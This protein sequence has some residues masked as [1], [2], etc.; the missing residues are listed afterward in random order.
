M[1]CCLMVREKYNTQLVN[2][3][4]DLGPIAHAEVHAA[5]HLGKATGV[6]HLGKAVGGRGASFDERR[7][8]AQFFSYHFLWMFLVLFSSFLVRH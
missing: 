6:I 3:N 4:E 2:G 5:F 7:V 8:R 1:G